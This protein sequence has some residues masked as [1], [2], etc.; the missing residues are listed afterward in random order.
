MKKMFLALLSAVMLLAM[1][2]AG[3]TFEVDFDD[4]GVVPGVA[5]GKKNVYRFSDGD[6][7]LRM[8]PGVNGKGNS[9]NLANSECAEYLMP[10]N[11]D[12][13]GGTVSVWVCPINWQLYGEGWQT[14]FF[15]WQK[16]FQ[17]RINKLTPG[18]IEATIVNRPAGEKQHALTA[19]ARCDAADWAPG[20]WHKIDVTWDEEKISLY[21]DGKIPQPTPTKIGKNTRVRPTN[22]I[23]LFRAKQK[24]PKATGRF[25][26]GTRHDWQTRKEVNR[27]HKTAIDSV[28]IR[29][30]VLGAVEIRK[31][32]EKII[33]P[34]PA[35]AAVNFATIP[36]QSG[37]KP[38]WNKALKMPIAA[39][40]APA[41][42]LQAYIMLAHNN[43]KLF[44][45]Y[46]VGKAP[47]K[48]RTP[49][50]VHDGNL[51]EEDSVEFY[52]TAPGGKQ[53][54][55][56]IFNSNGAIYDSRSTL[57][58][59]NGKAVAKAE[60]GKDFW[61]LE[62]A[63]PLNDLGGKKLLQ[64]GESKAEFCISIHDRSTIHYYHWGN[65]TG[66]N[67]K[68][69][70]LLRF[71]TDDRYFQID[72]DLPRLNAGDMKISGRGDL[73][74]EKVTA[75]I[76]PDGY[77]AFIYPADFNGVTWE[78]TLPAG[79]QHLA[80]ESGILRYYYDFSVDYPIELR[81]S[82]DPAAKKLKLEIDL[83]NAGNTAAEKVK[84]SGIPGVAQLLS[85][86]GKIVSEKKFL[87]KNVKDTLMLKLP[88]T[89]FQGKYSIN[90][91][92]SG[93]DTSFTRQIPFRVPDLSPYKARLGL[94][95]TIPDPWHALRE[96]GENR[97]QTLTNTIQIGG[98]AFPERI[99]HGNMELLLAPP[100][101]E[102]NGIPVKWEAPQRG[103]S[104]PDFV[105]YTGRGKAGDLALE[106][107]GELWF[108]G[109]W[110][111]DLDLVPLKKGAKVKSF[112]VSYKLPAE[113]GKFAMDPIY[114]PFKDK[115]EIGLG[116]DARRK[117]NILWLS[118]HEKGIF[119]WTKS[120]ANWVNNPQ[121][122]PL[123]AAKDASGTTAKLN[124]ISRPV[125]LPGKASYTMVFMGTP[126][127]TPMAEHRLVNYNG[128]LRNSHCNYQPINFGFMANQGANPSDMTA[129]TSCKPAY[130]D[131][132]MK[133]LKPYKERKIKNHIYTMPGQVSDAEA[134]YDYL[135][136]DNWSSPRLNHSGIKLGKPWILDYF[137][138]NATDLTADLW[139]WN[140]DQT[141]KN[142]PIEGLY[143]DVASTKF[144]ENLTHGCGG[145]DIF[146]QPYI[147][148]DALGLRNFLMRVYKTVHKNRGSI[149]L[150]SHVQFLP[151]SHGFIDIF[152]P[153]ENTFHIMAK[154]LD[155]GYCEEIP[156]EQYQTDFNWR[157]AGV[158]YTLIIQSGRLCRFTPAFKK[159]KNKVENSPEFALR[160]LTPAVIHDFN[161]WP[162]FVY[163]RT[164]NNW[165]IIREQIGLGKDDVE[166][167]GYWKN[168]AAIPAAGNTY[169]SYYKF[170]DPKAP[171][172]VMLIVSNFNRTPVKAE[173]KI[174]FAAL[175]TA[176]P[177]TVVNIWYNKN[178]KGKGVRNRPVKVS[179]IGN[180]EIPGNHFLLL[181]IK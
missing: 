156:L 165:W 116:G 129:L 48:T 25:C 110:I 95:H 144:C 87:I 175:G 125:T 84:T 106:W 81:H 4:Y 56:Y 179:D 2:L 45:K 67:Y 91:A 3:K 102:I 5:L 113:A 166:F 132:M 39:Q 79:G 176:I 49:A 16:D 8:F 167:C 107:K 143:F 26:I 13:K 130:R 168:K 92:T 7:Q 108:D 118:G 117:D 155:Y 38:D 65:Y 64:S 93:K 98:N 121:E 105:S 133:F 28:T 52:L 27:N 135:G 17:L 53:Q 140:I 172:K 122:K 111:L 114:V 18:Y 178:V 32:Y 82:C 101:W 145:K 85:P 41:P 37:D 51:W 97:F 123:T 180:I 162:T 80:V 139:S 76:T 163:N 148:S 74:G 128:Y 152:A 14:F 61:T 72:T 149:L 160:A 22:P 153:G 54:N 30:R 157:K 40:L 120:N 171:Y 36:C 63:I 20:R 146:G 169:C 159:F 147:T 6:L 173:M 33:P 131:E 151:M 57:V 170:N 112:N 88:G 73:K 19:V 141:M 71:G 89:L 115:V 58:S 62:A 47:L 60:K 10:Q 174:D 124:I 77:S 50:S 119:F 86:D 9:L 31:E 104:H 78:R 177:E 15:A 181:G 70:D 35:K 69:R 44:L 100:A 126:S 158:P 150:H 66:R 94:D 46:F 161:T 96:T 127:R 21:I 23:R 154:N 142:Y 137:C 1:C 12:P 138:F 34:A 24:Y 134:D 55:Q 109:A 136:R 90:V 29:N 83:T 42:R 11:F 43:D 99:T 59:W 103:K 68:A 164:V 75:G